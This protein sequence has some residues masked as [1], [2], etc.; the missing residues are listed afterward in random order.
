LGSVPA[1]YGEVVITNVL[2]QGFVALIA[3]A[4]VD[5]ADVASGRERTGLDSAVSRY[6]LFNT[7]AIF[8]VHIARHI[9]DIVA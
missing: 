9:Y 5:E 6:W 4:A 3:A 8:N 7:K 1:V 2:D